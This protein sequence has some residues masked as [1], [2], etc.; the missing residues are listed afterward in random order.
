MERWRAVVPIVL[1]LVIAV[2]ASV[3]I[4]KWMKK[5]T[6]P[7]K[8]AEKAKI[9]QIAVAE[10]EIPA[11][12]K[13]KSEM[14]KTV[15]FLEESLPQG[16]FQTPEK[17][18]GRIVVT[19]I[20]RTELIL[21]SRLAPKDVKRGGM[22]AI[23]KPGKRAVS[24]A[25][26]KVL[27]LSGLINPGDRVDILLTTA[28]PKKP[29]AQV[30]KTVFENVLIL[31]TGTQLSRNAEGKP[32]PVDNYTLEVTPEQGEKLIL[33]ASQ[34]KIH[35]ALRSVLDKETVLT[36]GATHPEILAS[37]RPVEP[38]KRAKSKLAVKE[39]GRH[40]RVQRGTSAGKGFTLEVIKGLNRSVQNF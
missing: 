40:T 36:T 9:V 23:V 39:G 3:L 15:Y 33:A 21:E 4:Y 2:V 37:Y 38:T 1:A 24:V 32:S 11:G 30:N 7:E 16:Y 29:D 12:T 5:Q 26:N 31:A 17:A 22:A 20:K 14:M 8:V 35:F 10:V 18:V 34:G 27:G 13:L 19:P 25:G 28:D 6:A